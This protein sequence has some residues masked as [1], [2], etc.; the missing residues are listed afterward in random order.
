[1]AIQVL[2]S[3]GVAYRLLHCEQRRAYTRDCINAQI[4]PFLLSIRPKTW[5]LYHLKLVL[6]K[7]HLLGCFARFRLLENRRTTFLPTLN[8]LDIRRHSQT[9]FRFVRLLLESS[10]RGMASQCFNRF[11]VQILPGLLLWGNSLDARLLWCWSVLVMNIIDNCAIVFILFEIDFG[12]L[13]DIGL[14]AGLGKPH[15]CIWLTLLMQRF[16]MMSANVIAEV[17]AFLHFVNV[18]F[19]SICREYFASRLQSFGRGRFAQ[20]LS[21]V[22]SAR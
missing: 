3:L 21:W 5:A 4:F 11:L 20:F 19:G 7:S 22:L 13:A 1:M 18:G 6:V 14:D 12:L 17:K 8:V 15:L 9:I 16:S 2:F 10:M